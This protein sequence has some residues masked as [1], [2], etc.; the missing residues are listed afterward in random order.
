M[1]SAV[2]MEEIVDQS[3]F[4]P[5]FEDNRGNKALFLFVGHVAIMLCA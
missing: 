3:I 4:E 5:C 1:A 2:F